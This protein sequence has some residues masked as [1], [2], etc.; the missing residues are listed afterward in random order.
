MGDVP[1]HHEM[2]LGNEWYG[3]VDIHMEYHKNHSRKNSNEGTAW[4][5]R[6]FVPSTWLVLGTP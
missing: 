5:P 4:N 2:H 1:E 3:V 6:S